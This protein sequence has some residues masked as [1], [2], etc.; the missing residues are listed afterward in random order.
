MGPSWPEEDHED[1]VG[2]GVKGNKQGLDGFLGVRIVDRSGRD[3]HQRDG[4]KPQTE[5]GS[6]EEEQLLL[7]RMRR[8]Q[9]RTVAARKEPQQKRH[10]R[11]TDKR[12]RNTIVNVITARR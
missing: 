11:D 8:F 7:R 10:V 9:V 6:Q 12:S 2:H 3:D 4:E 5:D 1:A